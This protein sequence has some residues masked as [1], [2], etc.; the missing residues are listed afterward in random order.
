MKKYLLLGCGNSRVNRFAEDGKWDGELVTLDSDS[1]CKPNVV[2][3]LSYGKLP[4]PDDEFNEIHAYEVLEHFGKQ[5]DFY[6]FFRI[7]EEFARVLKPD[8][9]AKLT[10][11]WWQSEWAW[12]DPGH[13]RVLPPASFV[14]LDQSQ[15]T[16]QVGKTAMS[17]YRGVYKADFSVEAM[18]QHRE[19]LSVILKVRK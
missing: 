14:F 10:V 18:E 3:D 7:F 12:G 6:A 2:W 13:T 9:V 11:P 17:D 4:F 5:G 19:Q 1:A 8:G 15:Y 16:K